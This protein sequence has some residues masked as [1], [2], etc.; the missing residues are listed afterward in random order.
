MKIKK[1]L[2]C[3][4][5]LAAFPCLP[6]STS[7]TAQ[8]DNNMVTNGNFDSDLLGWT[9]GSPNPGSMSWDSSASPDG[10]CLLLQG[11]YEAYPIPNETLILPETLYVSY[12]AWSPNTSG[13]LIIRIRDLDDLVWIS[14]NSISKTTLHQGW[15]TYSFE[16]TIPVGSVGNHFTVTFD[17]NQYAVLAELVYIDNVRA[18]DGPIVYLPGDANRDGAVNGSDAAILAANWLNAVDVTWTE[19]DFN[20]DGIVDDI[21]ATLMAANFVASASAVPEPAALVLLLGIIPALCLLRR[22]LQNVF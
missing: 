12:T 14:G 22:R 4:V 21:D 6:A 2:L 17:S 15:D 11:A 8:A 18:A 19:G 10:G 16:K 1:M 3:V 20:E 9:G 13:N 5:A 7:S